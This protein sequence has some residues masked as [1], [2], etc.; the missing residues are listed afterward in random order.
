MSREKIKIAILGLVNSGKTSI[1]LSLQRNVNLLSFYSIKPT[2]GINRV[3]FEDQDSQFHIWDFGG[4]E[5]YRKGYL[6]KLDSH[7]TMTNKIIYVIDVQDESKYELTLD[8]LEKILTVLKEGEISI[9]LSIFLHKF[10]PNMSFQDAKIS[11]LI[12][13]IKG[14][15]PPGFEYNI[16]KTTIYTVFRKILA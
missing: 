14:T 15:I 5:Q 9:N 8:F 16:F 1:V 12:T 7:L 4:Q 2:M 11:A 13:A 6:E 3:E 10:D